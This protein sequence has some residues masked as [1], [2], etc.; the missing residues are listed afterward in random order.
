MY[1]PTPFDDFSSIHGRL[2]GW[3]ERP[4]PR[5]TPD[6][7]F[8]IVA[9]QKGSALY[10]PALYDSAAVTHLVTRQKKNAPF[11]W[12]M[13]DGSWVAPFSPAGEV[14]EEG[15]D[16]LLIKWSD[17]WSGGA[18]YQRAAYRLD[19]QGLTVRWGDFAADRFAAVAPVLSPGTSCNDADVLCYDHRERF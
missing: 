6:E 2:G 10:D 1:A 19:G 11:Q 3:L 17:V 8:S 4:S 12:Q 14:L 5:T 16:S 18:V 13:P 9:I 15:P 7:T